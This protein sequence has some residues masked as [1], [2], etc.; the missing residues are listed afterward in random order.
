MIP[1]MHA[2]LVAHCLPCPETLPRHSHSGS[3]RRQVAAATFSSRQAG[4]QPTPDSSRRQRKLCINR[5]IR[6]RA[7]L[8]SLLYQSHHSHDT[9]IVV[10]F[11]LILWIW[12]NPVQPAF[13]VVALLTPPGLDS[14]LAHNASSNG[15]APSDLLLGWV[16]RAWSRSKVQG[17]A[18]HVYLVP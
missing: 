11:G 12:Q 6:L 7:F 18:Q 4:R 1:C 9:K 3:F 14:L 10:W 15:S 17:W 2:R 8:G 13:P 16:E 5:A